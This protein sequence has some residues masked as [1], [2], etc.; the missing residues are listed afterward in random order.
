VVV[1]II[2]IIIIIVIV[3]IAGVLPV[4]RWIDR[5]CPR[6]PERVAVTYKSWWFIARH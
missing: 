1:V 2:I 3:F 5:Q 4:Y 6:P